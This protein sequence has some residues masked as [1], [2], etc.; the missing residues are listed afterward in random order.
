MQDSSGHPSAGHAVDA[1]LVPFLGATSEAEARDQLAELLEKIAEPLVRRITRSRL[2]SSGDGE[3]ED[4]CSEVLLHLVSRLEALRRRDEPGIADFKGYVAVAAYNACHD[5]VRSRHPK[6][7]R[8]QSRL[9]YLLSHQ[10]GLAI[11][12]G[13]A[14]EAVCGFAEWRTAGTRALS[15]ALDR[16]REDPRGM[17][18][19]ELRAALPDLV[20]ALLD[21]LGGAVALDDLVDAVAR[22]LDIHDAPNAELS[23]AD[24]AAASPTRGEDELSRID[25]R[26]ALKRLWDEI[27]ALPTRQRTAL[28][29]NLRDPEGRD[30]I[31]LFP[32]TGTVSVRGI[33]DALEIP[34]ERF[35]TMW[36]DL[37]Y[38]D[39]AIAGLLGVTRQQVINLRKCARER[40]GRRLRSA[41]GASRM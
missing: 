36:P 23:E 24:G 3:A 19:P 25:E 32:L 20:A 26:R 14:D 22:I 17:A 35:A 5:H 7:W 12:E 1:L 15:R 40:L 38:E 21:R 34:A 13:P 41:G 37:P 6:R 11:W 30:A 33:A 31:A 4:V 10:P 28:L 9:R 39:S 27:A 8:L 2:R 29:L 16:L 18:G